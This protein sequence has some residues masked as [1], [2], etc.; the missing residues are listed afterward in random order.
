M[1]LNVSLVAETVVRKKSVSIQKVKLREL[2][3]FAAKTAVKTLAEAEGG[4]GQA[5]PRKM[6]KSEF[7]W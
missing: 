7:V 5:R 6:H 3:A 1:V 2:N 4:N